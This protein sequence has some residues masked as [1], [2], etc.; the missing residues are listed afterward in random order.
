M[1]LH[2]P[3]SL[4]LVRERDAALAGIRQLHDDALHI[5]QTWSI[6]VVDARHEVLEGYWSRFQSDQR[7][8]LLEFSEVE[9]IQEEH[10]SVETAAVTLFVESKAEI[11]RLKKMMQVNLPSPAKIPKLADIRMSTFSGIY[12]EWT[13]WRSEFAAK[14]M[15][16]ALIASEKISILL[17]SLKHEAAACARRAE[18]L[19]D[20]E[21]QRIWSKLEK[22]YDNKYQQAYAHIIEI[23]N[24]QPVAYASAEKSSTAVGR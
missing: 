21:F 22:T 4:G 6:E 16:T 3:S 5:G 24:I 15:D 9:T 17:S 12:T 18:R 2:G 8:L 23:L 19:D 14:V 10:S 7:R 13:S 1:A 11:T 20:L